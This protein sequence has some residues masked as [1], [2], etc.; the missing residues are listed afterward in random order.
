MT[1][2]CFGKIEGFS[3]DRRGAFALTFGR[4]SLKIAV[5]IE[6]RVSRTKFQFVASLLL[7]FW[8]VRRAAIPF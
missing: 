4:A 1:K 2:S 5:R 8:E 3:T 7:P 6:I